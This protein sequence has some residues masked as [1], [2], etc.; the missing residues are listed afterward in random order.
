[1]KS[2]CTGL[3]CLIIGAFIFGACGHDQRSA[4]E[5][6]RSVQGVK[7]DKVVLSPIQDYYEAVGTVT[8]KTSSILSSRIMGNVIALHVHEGDRVHAG[9]LLVEI[10]NRDAAARFQKAKAG[11]VEAQE[12]LE[13][14]ERSISTA[15]AAKAAAQ[16]QKELAAATLARYK[17]LIA[18]R[19]VS[20]QEFDE[21][22][23]KSSV[24]DA[25]ADRAEKM[26]Q[27]LAS[28]KKQVEAK[29][30]QARADVADAEVDAGYGRITSPIAGAVTAKQT[31]IG[32]TAAPGVPLLTIEDDSRY[33]LEAAVDESKVGRTRLGDSV[34]VQIDALGQ[35]TIEGRVAEIVPASDPSSRSYTVKVDLPGN[36]S[37]K[38]L[39]SGMFGRARFVVG[40][41]QVLSVPRPAIVEQGQLVSV[42]VVADS[43]IAR[44][45]LV[46]LGRALDD[47]VEILSGLSPGERIV[48]SGVEKVSDGARVQ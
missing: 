16:A 38:G 45:R 15:Q 8:S 14:A 6:P 46:K 22:Q 30:D 48:T 47:Q 20:Q 12:A 19:S 34:Q 41:K 5:E 33:R 36:E 10:D 40:E 27:S 32:Q 37:N 25:E 1:M 23:A 13:E 7:I 31:D 26:L 2:K 42:F 29:I 24:A 44:L 39:R 18:R 28:R 4:T 43:G 3:T 11:L 35:Q 9:Q 21:V 17:T